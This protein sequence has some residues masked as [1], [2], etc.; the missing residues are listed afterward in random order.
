MRENSNDIKDYLSFME[1]IL[2]VLAAADGVSRCLTS[3]ILP[4]SPIFIISLYVE[5]LWANSTRKRSNYQL[6]CVGGQ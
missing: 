5:A 6:G 1:V 3:N 4:E 2:M